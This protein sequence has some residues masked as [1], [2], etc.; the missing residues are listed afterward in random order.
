MR[1]KKSLKTI[2]TMAMTFALLFVLIFSSNTDVEAKSKVKNGTYNFAPTNCS[3]FVVKGKK[4]TI[5]MSGATIEKKG[6]SSFSKKSMTIPVAKKCKY[7]TVSVD[8]RTLKTVKT[9]SNY[10]AIKSFVSADYRYHKRTGFYG[11]SYM[12]RIIVKKG[13]VVRV[14][15]YA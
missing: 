2:L 15:Y 12:S 6:S 13:K 3:K 11:N 5:K 9:K 8:R 10:K 14:E 7:Y 1:N 4:L